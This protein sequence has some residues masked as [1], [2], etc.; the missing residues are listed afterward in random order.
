MNLNIDLYMMATSLLFASV[1]AWMW[2]EYLK[3]KDGHAN[4]K[5]A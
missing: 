4:K 2:L 3:K 5:T 1:V